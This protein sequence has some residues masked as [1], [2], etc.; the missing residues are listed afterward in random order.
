MF[1]FNNNEAAEDR[2]DKKV[3]ILAIQIKYQAQQL[4]IL[5]LITARLSFALYQVLHF[6][7]LYLYFWS[8]AQTSLLLEKYMVVVIVVGTYQYLEIYVIAIVVCI[9]LPFY[10][11]VQLVRLC[12]LRINSAKF[13][14]MLK[15]KKFRPVDVKGEHECS[16][17]ML[18][19]TAEDKIIT[20]P[21]NEQHHFHSFCIQTWL[22]VSI[23]CPLCRQSFAN[24]SR[25]QVDRIMAE[26]N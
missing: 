20:L 9:F 14:R 24:L 3:N 11:I 18:P 12:F 4:S 23:T 22:K 5:L 15:P 16:V 17:C 21:C 26:L 6:W 13:I 7:A 1:D 19:Y 25:G 2:D 10:G 8:E